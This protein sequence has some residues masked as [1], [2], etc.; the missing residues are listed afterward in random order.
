MEITLVPFY[1]NPFGK[2]SKKTYGVATLSREYEIIQ[3]VGIALEEK[4]AAENM[5]S[6]IEDLV[7]AIKTAGKENTLAVLNFVFEYKENFFY[8][9]D[10][11]RNFKTA[12]AIHERP[13]NNEEKNEFMCLMYNND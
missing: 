7:N 6:S 5:F 1:Q 13:L 8:E 10:R 9:F 4:T 11:G 12:S 2:N 3:A